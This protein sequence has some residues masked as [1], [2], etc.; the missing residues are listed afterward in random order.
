MRSGAR[1]LA[2]A[3]VF[4]AACDPDPVVEPDASVL[5]DGGGVLDGGRDAGSA[6][7]GSADAGSLD[8][9][10][11]DAGLD[12][13]RAPAAADR[14]RYAVIQRPF[15]GGSASDR[16][17][18]LSLGA[19]G[20]LSRTGTV[21][22]MGRAFQGVVS[23]TP[24]GE[25]GIIAQ[26][27]GS[28]GVFTL[29][30][31]GVPTVVH[32]AFE[33]EFYATGTV[34]D[35][36]GDAVW[37]LDAQF[38]N[39][40][41]GLYRVPIGCDGT[42]GDAVR[43]APA[44]L[45]YGMGFLDDGRAVVA[46]KDMLDVALNVG[47]THLVDLSTPAAVASARVFDHEDW[48]A[49]S[50]ALS[51]NGRHAFIGDNGLFS[52]PNRLGVVAVGADTLTDAQ[53]LTVVDAVAI[54]PSPFDDAVLVVSGIPNALLRFTYDA[55]ADP[56]LTFE[57]PLTYTGGTPLLPSS[58][59][60]VERGSLEGLVLVGENVAVRRVR[61]TGAGAIEDLGPLS[62]PETVG[63]IGLQP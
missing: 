45:P 46:A 39:I 16:W 51:H 12:C 1:V 8:A 57:G 37:V 24:D 60:M 35:P 18:V 38:R 50:F 3:L 30:A 10:P 34:M 63:A 52:D 6:D 22:T 44:Q 48:I 15:D 26:D 19:D 58:S 33:G 2:C 28:L 17:E 40:G 53:L 42:L 21:F 55:E 20:A 11:T 23:F 32:A 9:G 25:V 43:V 14:V 54:V 62:I 41:G 13:P 5:R 59:V 36:A 29:S 27:D 47:D 49:G 31:D 61:F 7:A 4:V 56:P